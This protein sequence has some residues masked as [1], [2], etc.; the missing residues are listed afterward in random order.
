MTIRDAMFAGKKHCRHL[1]FSCFLSIITAVDECN[2]YPRK[3]YMDNFEMTHSSHFPHTYELSHCTEGSKIRPYP[4]TFSTSLL[5]KKRKEEKKWCAV[6]V[7]I[8]CRIGNSI[9]L[10]KS[11]VQD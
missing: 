2:L 11:L 10:F 8:D 7:Y 9:A 3:K 1:Q 6:D 5:H 4:P